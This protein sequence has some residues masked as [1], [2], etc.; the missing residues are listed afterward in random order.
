M[1]HL[2][3]LKRDLRCD[4]HEP[5]TTAAT[6]GSIVVLYVY[7]PEIYGAPEFDPAHHRFIDESLAEL[8]AAFRERGARV[9]YRVGSMPDIRLRVIIE[10]IGTLLDDENFTNWVDCE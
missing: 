6:L 10:K 2:V 5:L 4:D 9:T 1:A 8:E 3:W 7:E